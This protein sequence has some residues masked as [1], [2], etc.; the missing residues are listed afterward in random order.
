M[1]LKNAPHIMWPLVFRLPHQP[2]LRP[3]WLI[4][5]GLFLY[6][7]LAKRLTLPAS[8]GIRFG[9]DSPLQGQISRGFEYADGWV[10]DARLVV[11][12]AVAAQEHG[13]RIL[14]RTRCIAARRQQ[15]HWQVT[16]QPLT[17]SGEATAATISLKTKSYR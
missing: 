4:R 3:A 10:D 14:T 1:L 7:N 8:R 15:D 5:L 17:A 11:L 12:N 13:A 6:D 9:A 16:L 2:H